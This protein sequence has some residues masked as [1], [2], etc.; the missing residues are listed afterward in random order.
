MERMKWLIETLNEAN[1]LYYNKNKPTLSDYEYDKLY[2]ELVELEKQTSTI[3][4]GSPTQNVG[5]LVLSAL[6]K[7]HHEGKVLSLDKTKEVAKLQSFLGDK[8]GVL[9]PKLDG[10]TIIATYKNGVL[11]KAIT[12]GNGE[13]GEDVTHNA[14]VF[15]NMPAKISF[16]GTLIVRGEAVITYS[17]FNK[18]NEAIEAED[19]YKNPRNLVSG[20][21]R[22][23]NSE[24]CARRNVRFFAFSLNVTELDSTPL[25]DLKSERLKWLSQLGFDTVTFNVV[26]SENVADYVKQYKESKEIKEIATDG[27]VLTYDSVSYSEAVGV[28]AKFPK[29]SIAFKWADELAE[30]TI[31]GMTWNT[32]RT[33]LINPVAEFAPVELEGSTVSRASVHNLSVLEGLAL[34]IGDTVTV[35]KA[36]MIIPQIAENLTRSGNVE[37]PK[38]CPVCG[39]ETEVLQENE[40]KTLY[41][42]NISCKAQLIRSI[43]HFASRDAMNIEGL[44]EATIEKF[45]ENGFLEN[46]TSIYF[47]DKFKEQI[48]SIRGFGE[49]SY[50]NLA[51]AIEHSKTVG[52]PNFIYALGIHQVGLSNAKLLC[53]YCDYDIE[54]IKAATQEELE[55]I[56]GYGEVI[57]SAVC[58]Y[59]SNPKNL[60]LLDIALK[61]LSFKDVQATDT[62][63][64]L[65]GLT[66]VI[67]G[68]LNHFENRKELTEKIEQLGGKVTG[69][70]S[71]KTNFLI[72]NDVTSTSGKNKKAI[73]LGV[74]IIG[75][76][77]L[78]QM[79]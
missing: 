62:D 9:S 40:G 51:E 79:M 10:L 31:T 22:Q 54:K 65:N 4:S 45:V 44:S 13:I 70:V 42:P 24:I 11:E 30:T 32:S 77:E 16:N 57:A 23:L 39:A 36:N 27:L 64:T 8:N 58:R 46:Y 37:I 3:Y 14:K 33:G 60:E 72:N 43:T 26:N 25:P 73:E 50:E 5:F 7:V 28:T 29:D 15:K 2:D 68:D 55:T 17:D 69:S 34:G 59:F 63:K 61:F 18:I 1:N 66:F 71:A 35:Y 21:V 49:K 67:T 12:R 38:K 78:L 41:C 47:L 48:V 76:V 20:T 6:K 56:D 74:K 52:L 53:K 75:E 19:K